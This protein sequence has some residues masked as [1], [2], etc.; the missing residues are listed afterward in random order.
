M[1]ITSVVSCDFYNN[2]RIFIGGSIDLNSEKLT[3]HLTG[4]MQIEVNS[5]VGLHVLSGGTSPDNVPLNFEKSGNRFVGKTI[6]VLFSQ[7][8]SFYRKRNKLG[9]KKQPEFALIPS[10]SF[11]LKTKSQYP[12]AL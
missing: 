4:K 10:P 12:L 11:S 7:D 3:G 2:R 1:N 9:R 5:S 6:S 8:Q